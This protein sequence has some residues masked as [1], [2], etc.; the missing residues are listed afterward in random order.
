MDRTSTPAHRP[1]YRRTWVLAVLMAVAIVLFTVLVALQSA[2]YG[3]AVPLA[4]PLGAALCGAHLLA[5]TRPR[6]AIGVFAVA[7][8]L[9]PLLASAERDLSWPWPWSVPAMIALVVFVLVVTAFHDWRAGLAAWG[10]P[11][12]GSLLIGSLFAGTVPRS[13]TGVDLLVTVSLGAGALLVGVLIAGRLRIGEQLDREREHTASEQARRLLVEERTRIARELHDIVA[14]STSLI[15]VQA[16]TAEYRIPDL[17]AEAAGEFG[18]IA[19]TARGSL[20]EMRRLL[21]V[22]RTEDHAPE[23]TPQRRL[24]DISELVDGARRAGAEVGLSMPVGSPVL[25]PGVQVTAFRITQEALSNAV[26]HAPGAP[27]E[28]VLDAP[29]DTLMIRVR[30]SAPEDSAVGEARG[31]GHGLR[32]MRERAALL[33]G[34]LQA[35]PDRDGGWTVTATLPIT[36]H[37][38]EPS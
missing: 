6:A 26:R 30:N 22:L 18:E 19:E 5:L 7:A 25:P 2:G 32:G 28:V 4:I 12:A 17:P 21:G 36:D 31:S 8:V 9:L 33:G 34:S 27:V 24:E 16:S 35:G 23:L 38:E 14:H 11:S 10:I 3:T 15:Q 29:Q 37:L 1:P 13:M 20:V